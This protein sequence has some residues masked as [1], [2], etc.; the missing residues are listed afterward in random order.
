MTLDEIRSEVLRLCGTPPIFFDASGR[1][2]EPRGDTYYL[3]GSKL[4]LLSGVY[5]TSPHQLYI[6][7]DERNRIEPVTGAQFCLSWYMRRGKPSTPRVP[8]WDE[9]V[10][11]VNS[12]FT[13]K[14]SSGSFY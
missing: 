13:H 10:E 1:T 3:S 12:C 11:E 4:P 8:S 6:V 2:I 14:V 5:T 7:L 9:V